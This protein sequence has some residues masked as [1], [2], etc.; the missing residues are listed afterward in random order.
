MGCEPPQTVLVS[1]LS[2]LDIPAPKETVLR[3]KTFHDPIVNP[4][5]YQEVSLQK[6][7]S[8]PIKKNALILYSGVELPPHGGGVVRVLGG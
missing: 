7:L 6:S 2:L 5:N 3:P 8:F 4:S 1:S